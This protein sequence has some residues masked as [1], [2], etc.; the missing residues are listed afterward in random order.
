MKKNH[1]LFLM[2]FLGIHFIAFSQSFTLVAEIK[3]QPANPVIF[4]EQKGDKFTP[5]DSAKT[6]NNTVKFSFPENAHPGVYRLI[7]GQTL[8]ARMMNE[9]P[10]QLDVIFNNENI[11]LET[12]FNAPE[13][14]LLVILSEENRVWL[15]FKR[16]EI[17]F[18]EELNTVEKEVDFYRQTKNTEKLLQTIESYNRLQNRRN[19]F[20]TEITGKN[21]GLLA[22][23]MILL[24]REPFLDGNLSA[25]ERKHIFQTEYLKNK[26]FSNENLIYSQVYTDMVFSYLVSFNQKEFTPEQRE[27]EYQKAVDLILA[28]T[29]KNQTVYEFI[30]GYLVHGFEV[31]QMNRLIEYIADNYAETTCQ[32]DEKTTLERKLLSQKMKPGTVVPDFTMNDINGDPVTLSGVL[33]E[34]TLLLFWASWC[35]HCNEMISFLKNRGIQKATMEVIT[36][37]LDTGETE[38]K[39][40]VRKHNIESWF[41]LCD[42][43]EWDGEAA[44]EYN[45]YATPTI[46]IIDKNRRIL[47]TP[48]TI[49]DLVQLNL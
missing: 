41:N 46:F 34:K 14:K 26:N 21:P 44:I 25:Q 9:P 12:D 23:E 32:T 17:L 38:W 20:I 35:P 39:D 2:L 19:E 29:N 22:S 49:N 4:G 36:I 28:A 24:F 15:E 1:I 6:V 16:R 18:R 31:L 48:V 37:S 45:I 5:I 13:N 11:I 27:T 40:A 10:Q 30:L 3:N 7:F 42:F 8:Y 43:Q 47:A 33:K